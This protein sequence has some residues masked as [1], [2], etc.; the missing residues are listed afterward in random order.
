MKDWINRK[1]FHRLNQMVDEA[2]NGTFHETA[3]DESEL[4][5]LEV[6]WKRFLA[7]SELTNSKVKEERENIKTLVSDISHQT[8]TPIANILLY[9]QLLKEQ[10][11]QQSIR[12]AELELLVEIEK[13]A[14]KLD[15]Q[16][17]SLMKLSR[18]ETGTVQL[19]PKLQKIHPMLL[20]VVEEAYP[21][22]EKKNI[23][24]T[25]Q[26][27]ASD[28]SASF[29]RKWTVEALY[30]ILDN[31]VK[32]SPEESQINISITEYELFTCIN[33]EDHGI[34][35]PEEEIPLI[36]G[37]FYRSRQVNEE[38]GVGIGLYLAREIITGQRGYIKAASEQGHGSKFSAYLPKS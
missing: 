6:K 29:D 25:L 27:M 23:L 11:E 12:T 26:E 35:I 7:M 9:T 14:E 13:Q 20:E 21:K 36:F 19:E 37:R 1:T 30:N 8:K 38:E 10:M 28:A 4:S 15:F 31:A 22:A 24:I 2:T 33:I 18:L 5:K 3:Y 34:G 17:K 32:Y 16:I